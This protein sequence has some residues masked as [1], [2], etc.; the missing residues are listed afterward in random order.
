MIWYNNLHAA[1]AIRRSLD[2]N[3]Q[4]SRARA[5]RR[6]TGLRLVSP[7]DHAARW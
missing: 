4:G 7:S 6:F 2:E 5:S 1:N 3:H